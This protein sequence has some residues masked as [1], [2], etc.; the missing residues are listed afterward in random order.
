MNQKSSDMEEL[1]NALIKNASSEVEKEIGYVTKNTIKDIKEAIA[2]EKEKSIAEW[3]TRTIPTAI[4]TP[5]INQAVNNAISQREH[6]LGTV[7]AKIQQS[8]IEIAHL[9]ELIDNRQQGFITFLN[10]RRKDFESQIQAVIDRETSNTDGSTLNNIL[11][12]ETTTAIEQMVKIRDEIKTDIKDHILSKE[13]D[14]YHRM[15]NLEKEVTERLTSTSKPSHHDS[16][17][18]HDVPTTPITSAR[19]DTLDTDDA[20]PTQPWNHTASIMRASIQVMSNIHRFKRE[21]IH[22][23]LPADPHQDQ[24][25]HFYNA[26]VT[27]L[28]SNKMPIRR[29]NTL[30]P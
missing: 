28:E 17:T 14:M 6:T 7:D 4:L 30:Q 2:I 13:Q 25:E 12:I 10:I 19:R 22:H 24:L 16:N 11:K 1:A 26:L 29:L 27:S 15:D 3:M 5:Q 9:N 20:T 21:I 23:N 8:Q 18:Q